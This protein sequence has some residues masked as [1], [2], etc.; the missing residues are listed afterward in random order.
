[1]ARRDDREGDI[2]YPSAD[3]TRRIPMQRFRAKLYRI[4]YLRCVD[5]PPAVSRLLGDES[6]IPVCGSAAGIPFRSTLTPR[7]SGA[8]RLFVHSRI[9]R[10]RR[11][12]I[13]DAIE[14]H[15]ERDHESREPDTPYDLLRALQKRP[16][17]LRFYQRASAALRREIGHWLAAAKRPETR[18]RRIEAALDN[19]ET[20]AAPN[21]KSDFTRRRR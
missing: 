12:D 19:L 14:V 10:P 4:G 15:I 13:G 2:G 16:A 17:A 20:R 18:E 21:R 8:H 5:V 9:W 3:R 1:M 11:L 7:G 6:V